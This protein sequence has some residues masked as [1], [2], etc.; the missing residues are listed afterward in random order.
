MCTFCLKSL[1]YF[2]TL[3]Q[4]LC[5]KEI[6]K[7]MIEYSMYVLLIQAEKILQPLKQKQEKE[8]IVHML[9]LVYTLLSLKRTVFFHIPSL[10]LHILIEDFKFLY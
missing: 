10:R 2:H 4:N 7:G 5:C 8:E 1:L 9:L 6:S 3:K